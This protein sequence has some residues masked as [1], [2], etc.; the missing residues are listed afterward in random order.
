M[1]VGKV[2]PETFF[3]FD[4]A[5]FLGWRMTADEYGMYSI[6]CQCC[7]AIG[8]GKDIRQAFSE[9]IRKQ[10]KGCNICIQNSEGDSKMEVKFIQDREN[11][12]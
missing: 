3:H 1:D 5:L 11:S 12:K 10:I 2:K 4:N 8:M 9:I 6:D 7:R